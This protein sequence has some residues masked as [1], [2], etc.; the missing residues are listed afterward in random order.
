PEQVHLELVPNAVDGQELHQSG[1]RDA[2]VVDE[3]E[4]L[5]DLLRRRVDRG[6]VRDVDD[7]R[8]DPFRLLLQRFPVRV[9]PNAREDVEPASV[10]VAHA[11]YRVAL[12]AASS[13][14][15]ISAHLCLTAWNPPMGRPNCSRSFAYWTVMSSSRCA[16]PSISAHTA[17][18]KYRNRCW[19]G[20]SSGVAS[21]PSS[22]TAPSGRVR[23]YACC[24]RTSNPSSTTNHRWVSP[25]PA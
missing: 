15:A 19:M 7:D 18:T 22:V 4:Q 2:G 3:A 23:S 6:L 25:S 17:T 24:G 16:T 11:A 14:T 10:S 8:L 9:L 12:R 20:I 5:V 21:T 1:H 13:S